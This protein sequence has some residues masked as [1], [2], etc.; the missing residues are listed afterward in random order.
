MKI[1]RGIDLYIKEECYSL[2]VEEFST[3]SPLTYTI[4]ILKLLG[5][6]QIEEIKQYILNLS[7]LELLNCVN[8]FLLIHTELTKKNFKFQGKSFAIREGNKTSNINKIEVYEGYY[9]NSLPILQERH[10]KKCIQIAFEY[11]NK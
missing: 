11:V 4:A 1:L 7:S 5:I 6:Q 2:G 3:K 10:I 9:H 8:V